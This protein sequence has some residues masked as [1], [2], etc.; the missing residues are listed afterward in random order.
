VRGKADYEDLIDAVSCSKA[1]RHSPWPGLANPASARIQ[2]A[3]MTWMLFSDG[4]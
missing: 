2:I 4:T 3:E 1:L